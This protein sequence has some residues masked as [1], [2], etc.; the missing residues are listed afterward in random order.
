MIQIPKQLQDE[1]FRFVLLIK[2]EKRAFEEKWQTI[3]NYR[4]YDEELLS[5]LKNGGNYGVVAGFGYLIIIEADDEC[6]KKILLEIPFPTFS[7]KSP[8]HNG[9]HSYYFCKDEVENIKFFGINGQDLGQI[10]AHEKYVVGAGSTHPN[11]KKYEVLNDLPIA[12]ITK[13]TIEYFFSDYFTEQ[14][15]AQNE[16]KKI[17]ENRYEIPIEKVLEKMDLSR[18]RKSGHNYYGAHPIHGSDTGNNFHINTE[19]NV[20]HCFRHNTGGGT[21]LLVALLKG[22]VKCE[23]CNRGVFK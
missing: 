8:G 23:E 19:K 22:I 18:F 7:V 5:H 14:K 12:E 17:F 16:Q 21:L 1:N 3:K 6:I 13:P 20:W 11:G 2:N 15:P 4:Y 9:I 10:Q